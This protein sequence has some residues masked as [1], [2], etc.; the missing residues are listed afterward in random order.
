[1][2]DRHVP[3]LLGLCTDNIA[4]V[5]DTAARSVFQV[6]KKLEEKSELANKLIEQVREMKKANKYM[7][8]QWYSTKKNKYV[9]SWLWGRAS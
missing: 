7:L 3:L 8:R 4:A 2:F 9:V 1:M 5:R 6:Y